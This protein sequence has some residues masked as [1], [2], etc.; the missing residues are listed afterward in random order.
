MGELLKRLGVTFDWF[1]FNPN[2]TRDRVVQESGVPGYLK[3]QSF[4]DEGIE[5]D[6]RYP[7]GGMSSDPLY[8]SLIPALLNGYRWI[9]IGNEFS[10]NVGNMLFKGKVINHQYVKSFED[11]VASS[12]FLTRHVMSGPSFFSL[13]WPFYEIRLAQI[14]SRFPKYFRAFVSCNNGVK[15]GIWCK[16]CPKCAFIYLSLYPFLAEEEIKQIFGEDLFQQVAIRKHIVDLV[17][18]DIRPWECIGTLDECKLALRMALAKLPG[19]EF[20]NRPTRAEMLKHVEGFDEDKARQV[21]LEGFHE[22]HQLPFELIEP[23]REMASRITR[24]AS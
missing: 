14:F 1:S 3:L 15:R 2:P 19:E 22:P 20:D 8:M 11:E 13:L 12:E 7:W 18:S 16:N 4:A 9:C 17:A 5:R 23:L 10:A 21:Y 24:N 6:R